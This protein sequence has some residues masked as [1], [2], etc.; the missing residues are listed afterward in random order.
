MAEAEDK[1]RE[2]FISFEGMKENVNGDTWGS[3]KLHHKLSYSLRELTAEKHNGQN[4]NLEQEQENHPSGAVSC[5]TGN[6]RTDC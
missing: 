1:E 4:Q 6:L 3:Q 5:Q 2:G